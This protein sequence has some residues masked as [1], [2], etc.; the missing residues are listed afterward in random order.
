LLLGVQEVPSSNLGGPTKFLKDLQFPSAEN[1]RFG[2]QLE[3]K[4]PDFWTPDCR[5][6]ALRRRT[7]QPLTAAQNSHN[8]QNSIAACARVEDGLDQ[9]AVELA[10]EL[11]G[12][13]EVDVGLQ[14]NGSVSNTTRINVL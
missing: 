6:L 12:S 4:R 2:V 8:P 11:R 7:A 5:V 14:V 10:A 9:V 13:G 3:S 1:R